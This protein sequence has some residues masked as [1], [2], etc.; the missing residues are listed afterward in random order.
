MKLKPGLGGLLQ[1]QARKWIRHILQLSS[2]LLK[3]IKQ[4]TQLQTDLFGISMFLKNAGSWVSS[5]A[6]DW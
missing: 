1:H 4:N 5:L 6:V 3:K 2:P